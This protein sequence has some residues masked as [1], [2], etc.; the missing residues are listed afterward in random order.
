[1][2]NQDLFKQLE[3]VVGEV[4]SLLKSWPM[5]KD[6][7]KEEMPEAPE[8]KAPAAE[9][10]EEG[11]AT[12]AEAAQEG[13]EA[14]SADQGQDAD[15]EM[16][17]EDEMSLEQHAEAMSD[18]ELHEMIEVLMKE[19]EKRHGSEAGQETAPQMSPDSA[20]PE[21]EKSSEMKEEYN[22]M[23]KSIQDL[24]SV[25]E[26]MAARIE[27]FEAMGK[28]QKQDKAQVVVVNQ[29]A[30]A[31]NSAEVM[32]KSQPK[33]QRLSKSETAEFLLGRLRNGD[34]NVSSDDVAHLSTLRSE[35]D[36]HKFQDQ[37]V[38]RGIELPKL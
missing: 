34:R 9:G 12:E 14:E 30:P 17:S 1:M 2:K 22:K 8:A 15:Q 27:S 5:K 23:H 32:T 7:D 29:G 24:A 36:V 21:M 16:S 6:E 20:A 26:K 13:A 38:K 33:A 31:M 25:V 35:A 4:D 19:L 18:E 3:Q 37:L 10:A 28:S 11:K